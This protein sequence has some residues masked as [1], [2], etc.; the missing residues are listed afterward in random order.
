[1]LINKQLE[2]L[3]MTKYRL[4]KDSGVPQA[5]INDNLFFIEYIFDE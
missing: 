4:S 5:T 1:M 2:R 3:R